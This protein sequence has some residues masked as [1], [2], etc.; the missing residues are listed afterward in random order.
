MKQDIIPVILAGGVGK[1]LWP[2]STRT[3]PKQFRKFT[4]GKTRLAET[5]DRVGRTNAI[6]LTNKAYA[7]LTQKEFSGKTLYEPESRNTAPAVALAALQSAP[8]AILLICPS[9]HTFTN[10]S[11][12]HEAITRAKPYADT[13]NIII[14]GVPPTHA[15][16]GYGYIKMH[17][18]KVQTFTEKPDKDTAK[19]YLKSGEYLWNAGIFMAKASTLLKAFE[20]HAP[21]ILTAVKNAD[22]STCPSISF[23]HA[24]LEHI[25]NIHCEP[26][27]NAGW[28]DIGTWPSLIK[29]IAKHTCFSLTRST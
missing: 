28:S 23:D 12:L 21:E 24:I 6:I 19:S 27:I 9:D 22:W 25:H 2:L 10:P 8:N 5:L 13:N 16:T 1:R 7:Q 14:F 26:L 15:H 20:T 11:A 4:N 18:N 3:K 29:H 17:D